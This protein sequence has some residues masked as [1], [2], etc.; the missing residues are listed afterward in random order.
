[1]NR[2]EFSTALAS[3][4]LA[5]R[6]PAAAGEKASFSGCR[7]VAGAVPDIIGRERTTSGNIFW[8]S[9]CRLMHRDIIAQA[10]VRAG[11][12]FYDD[13]D[14]ANALAFPDAMLPDGPD[15]TIMLG[16]KLMLREMPPGATNP[17]VPVVA[18]LI[19]HECGHILQY[20]SGMLPSG[21]W[22]MEPHADFLGGFILGKIIRQQ[23]PSPVPGFG[24][25]S[26]GVFLATQEMFRYG[27]VRFNSPEHHGAP[28]FRAAMV[29]AG[30]DASDRDL[31]SAFDRGKR[32]AGLF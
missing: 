28:E 5:C 3:A 8:D 24:L 14:G 26:M 11:F 21:P 16:I 25:D 18:I 10:G 9:H 19:A 27:D 12:C 7:T 13:S 32:I 23:P 22:R 30:L 20:K 4:L 17:F 6:C 1:M 2:R 29:R 15:G 31:K